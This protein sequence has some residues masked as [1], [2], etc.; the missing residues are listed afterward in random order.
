MP[1]HP[2]LN[3]VLEGRC[4]VEWI[5]LSAE[6]LVI[7]DW[8]DSENSKGDICNMEL[9]ILCGPCSS[10]YEIYNFGSVSLNIYSVEEEQIQNLEG[11][12]PLGSINFYEEACP[13]INVK[14]SKK[15]VAHLL[16]FIAND[17]SGLRV[18][19]SIPDWED[20][21]AK[22]LPLMSYQVFYEKDQKM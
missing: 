13:T 2:S 18:R 12:S 11:D 17:L 5:A 1:N 9:S 10:E 3:D 6:K 16:P 21:L 7:R 14:L 8:A 22:F 4:N 19:I 15:L 20:K